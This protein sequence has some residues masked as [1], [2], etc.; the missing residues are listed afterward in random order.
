M[1]PGFYTLESISN[2][3]LYDHEKEFKLKKIFGEVKGLD[4]LVKQ[5]NFKPKSVIFEFR[6]GDTPLIHTSFKHMVNSTIE[7]PNANIELPNLEF[8][9]VA[10]KFI[11]ML[12]FHRVF[13]SDETLDAG[14][15]LTIHKVVQSPYFDTVYGVE[16]MTNLSK[17]EKIQKPFAAWNCFNLNQHKDSYREY[18]LEKPMPIHVEAD[19]WWPSQNE[20]LAKLAT[21][22]KCKDFNFVCQVIGEPE[23]VKFKSEKEVLDFLK[24]HSKCYV[25]DDEMKFLFST[26]K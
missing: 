26:G 13:T 24:D 1:K 14:D 25:Y 9:M 4:L 16:S 21:Q 22:P 18:G 5:Y 10:P 20:L 12:K 23:L 2:F 7:L 17:N 11:R 3:P 8:K 15:I 6:L 19:P